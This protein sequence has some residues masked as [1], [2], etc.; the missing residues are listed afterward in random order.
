M[1]ASAAYGGYV[2]LLGV[3]RA[4][5]FF[6][7]AARFSGRYAVVAKGSKY[8]LLNCDGQL[9]VPA[10]YD[11]IKGF[12]IGRAWVR[13]GEL[14]GLLD[15]K[16]KVLV[17]PAFASVKP[18]GA[19]STLA[20]VKKNDVW[21]LF[22]KDRVR[23][24]I[25]PR[26][27]AVRSFSDSVGLGLRGG[28]TAIVY[29]GNGQVIYDSCSTVREAYPN[30]LQFKYRNHFGIADS[31]GNMRVRPIYDSIGVYPHGLICKEGKRDYLLNR[32]G[33][34]LTPKGYIRILGGSQKYFVAADDSGKVDILSHEGTVVN[35]QYQGALAP[36]S[37]L[38]PVRKGQKWTLYNVRFPTK[39]ELPY[40]DS[41]KYLDAGRYLAVYGKPAGGATIF[42]T[43]DGQ[44]VQTLF[45]QASIKWLDEAA[46][47]AILHSDSGQNFFSYTT[48]RLAFADNY[49]SIN[50]VTNELAIVKR[51]AV[52]GVANMAQNS[53]IIQP[54]YSEITPLSNA[55]NIVFSAKIAGGFEVVDANGK[56]RATTPNRPVGW[57]GGNL[58]ALEDADGKQ[59][60]WLLGP[61]Q[62]QFSPYAFERLQSLEGGFAVGYKKT[63]ASVF[64]VN[65]NLVADGLD[66]AK[67][68][69]RGLFAV[70]RDGKWYLAD[71][72]FKP[73]P[74]AT[75]YS[76]L[77]PD[78]LGNAL[79]QTD[80]GFAFLNKQGL[81]AGQ[82]YAG[83][84]PYQQWVGM[85][86][87]RW[88]R[89]ACYCP[90]QTAYQS[91]AAH[92]G[93][94]PAV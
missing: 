86:A 93:G 44:E 63:K 38:L 72:G 43:T 41:V 33:K 51:N 87:A 58:Y 85:R 40:A 84:I 57:M 15:A 29:L 52:Y 94:G 4:E 21:G 3:Y 2:N 83:A 18:V 12:Y 81:P 89:V 53:I 49:K 24:L 65:G 9:A 70:K 28:Y 26:Y 75:G 61:N 46:K 79:A 92:A 74:N 6:D 42:Y 13:Q 35:T 59:K 80:A 78:G 23:M 20:W 11:E 19:T 5:P 39:T 67:S 90:K 14:W 1:T 37:P 60:L 32:L 82:S 73:R 62:K 45:A 56:V 31:Y 36:N 66:S 91:R 88:Q 16:G 22:D 55:G 10:A 71:G 34:P 47:G 30:H 69:S 48:G 7:K 64:N 50:L 17:P 68:L 76:T 27:V 8:G 77:S 25:D 54:K